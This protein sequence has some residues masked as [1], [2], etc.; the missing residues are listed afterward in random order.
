MQTWSL[1]GVQRARIFITRERIEIIKSKLIEILN[2]KSKI[3]YLIDT[4]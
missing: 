4:T 3:N 1:V 2:M